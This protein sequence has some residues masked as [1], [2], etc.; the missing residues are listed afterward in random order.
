M[1]PPKFW[2][3]AM[4]L[5]IEAFSHDHLQSPVVQILKVCILKHLGDLVTVSGMS[6][7]QQTK[8]I[9]PFLRMNCTTC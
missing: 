1:F 8:T 7:M 5:N 2:F 3:S 4:A 6:W 9:L